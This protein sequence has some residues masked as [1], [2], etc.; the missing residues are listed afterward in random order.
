MNCGCVSITIYSIYFVFFCCNLCKTEY[1]ERLQLYI[2]IKEE[3]RETT[4]L[5]TIEETEEETEDETEE[6]T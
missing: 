4:R 3:Y 1:D 2:D 5:Y 6:E